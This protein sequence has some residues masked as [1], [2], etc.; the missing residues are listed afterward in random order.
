MG[1]RR[2][3]GPC[4]HRPTPDAEHQISL[5]SLHSINTGVR[6][7]L[8]ITPRAE[9]RSLWNLSD[10]RP[11]HVPY[12]STTLTTRASDLGWTS[13]SL[14]NLQGVHKNLRTNPVHPSSPL[15]KLTHTIP[16]N[17]YCFIHT[18]FHRCL[19]LSPSMRVVQ[20]SC[21]EQG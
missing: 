21:A 20:F 11:P 1:V 5:V 3:L 18:K 7:C 2:A 16:G 6:V 10:R 4:V 15:Q 19:V 14:P 13:T 9:E 8:C 17:T 12:D